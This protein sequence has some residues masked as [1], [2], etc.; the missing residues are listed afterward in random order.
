M[1]SGIHCKHVYLH[2]Y[3]DSLHLS[4]NSLLRYFFDTLVPFMA[5]HA[6]HRFVLSHALTRHCT[7]LLFFFGA[8]GT[9][10]S[11]QSKPKDYYNNLN[12]GC[13][14]STPRSDK[15]THRLFLQY[16]CSPT[17]QYYITQQAAPNLIFYS[18]LMYTS[19]M[20][21][22]VTALPCACRHLPVVCALQTDLYDTQILLHFL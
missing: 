21:D 17:V 15:L 18:S 2:S 13:P 12:K 9:W 11:Q 22:E 3:W 16:L 19:F 10:K 20:I 6:L 5:S 7:F 14:S 4:K 1:I 8:A